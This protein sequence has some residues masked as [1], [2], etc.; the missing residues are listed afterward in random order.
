MAA[1]GDDEWLLGCLFISDCGLAFDSG[2][3]AGEDVSFQ[4]GFLSWEVM[5]NLTESEAFSGSQRKL[6][7][8]SFIP[9]TRSYDSLQLQL[10]IQADAEWLLEF[11]KLRASGPKSTMSPKQEP[12]DI[13]DEDRGIT[14]PPVTPEA[15]LLSAGGGTPQPAEGKRS[16]TTTSGSASILQERKKT[17]NFSK[18]I[19]RKWSEAISDSFAATA[20]GLPA[21]EAP[22][23]EEPLRTERLPA[24]LSRIA[25]VLEEDDC[26]PRL[27]G[28]NLKAFELSACPWAKSKKIPGTLVRRV[29]FR[30][31]VPQDVPKVISRLI[32]LPETTNVTTVYR[33]R[34]G[35]ERLVLT[36][37]TCTHDVTFGENFRVQET[38]SFVP[39]SG[40]G[41]EVRQWIE[42]VWVAP[43]PWTHSAI[44]SYIEKKTKSD[45]AGAIAG[46]LALFKTGA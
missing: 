19:T 44:K 28:R 26:L 46:F 21:A 4:T 24:A 17:M 41:A 6:I 14:M 11:W 8:A 42:V 40:G 7:M 9:G 13:P 45:S 18:K 22:T 31:N 34:V 33:L 39:V 15:R 1:F 27:L 3:I 16:R 29:S 38:Y 43:L 23:A 36:Y 2:R 10:S 12:W 5:S 37:Q 20:A 30:M 25:A 32:S 35:D